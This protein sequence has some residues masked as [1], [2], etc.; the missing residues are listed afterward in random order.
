ML[1]V[2]TNHQIIL[3][4]FREG[5][6]IRKIAKKLKIHRGT[7]S[8]RIKE[9]EQ[10]KSSPISDQDDPKSLL[11][12]YLKTGSIYHSENR[13]KRKL[14]E[15]MIA[16]IAKCLHNNEIKRLDGRTKQQVK[17]IDIHEQLLS[18]GHVISYSSV[19]KYIETKVTQSQEAFIRQ[20]YAE[21][22]CCEFDWAECKINLDGQYK[23]YYLAVFT[24][25]FSNYRYALLFKHQDSLAFKE[26]H[27]C[28]YEHIGGV[29]QQM[30]YD[31]MRVAIAK[32]VG[33][34][35]K[36]PTEGLLQLSR[37]YQ[38]QWRFCNRAKVNEKGHVERSVEYVRRKVFGFK[39]EFKTFTEAQSYLLRRV[40][41]L[42]ERPATGLSESAAVKLE[43][44]RKGLSAHQ[45]RMECYAGENH[46][47]DKYSTI[48]FGT[49]RYSV[50]DHMIG[51]MVFAKI[52]SQWIKIY[53]SSSVLCQHNRLY[54]RFDWQIDINHY[55][56]TL[57]RKPGAVAGSIA[58]KQ[59]PL[60]VQSIYSKHFVHDARSFI[61]LLQYCQLNDIGSQQ[62]SDCVNK[63]SRQ[64]PDGV[65]TTCVMALLGNQ[66]PE[67]PVV[68]QLPDPIALQSM[69]NLIQLEA[70]MHYN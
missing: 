8:A 52:Y 40:E 4:F 33:K 51:K 31:N 20:Q 17:K 37:W 24:S 23:R 70:M 58:L 9:Y 66:Q 34:T 38:Y 10:F 50:P 26:A 12:Q 28:F 2:A 6:S 13:E 59:A 27:I 47:V 29:Y 54:E 55:L 5:L 67:V 32:F 61:E 39:D 46:K 60:W 56:V 49:N 18:A 7:V 30:V 16:I 21:G 43:L 36:I 44:E 14:S 64:F 68:S 63:L 41:E 53:D 25:A 57:Q 22:S 62:M 69:E 15:E 19:C 65:N 45:G 42:N 3:L 11:N 1:D 48:C 35:E